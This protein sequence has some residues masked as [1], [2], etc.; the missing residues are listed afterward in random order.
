MGKVRLAK[1]DPSSVQPHRK[2]LFIGRSGGGKSV[3]MRH[4]LYHIRE[5]IDM[6][7]GFTPTEETRLALERFIPPSCVHDSLDLGVIERAFTTQKALLER[8]KERSLALIADDCAFDKQVWRS[9]TI[10]SAFMNG[11]HYRTCLVL[12]M[13]YMMDLSPDLRTNVDYVISTAEN[14]HANKR[15]L[16]Q[17]FF[18]VF[19]TYSEFDQVFSA[20][21]QDWSCIVLDQTQPSASVASSVFWWKADPVLPPFRLGR[22]VFFKLH[23]RPREEEQLSVMVR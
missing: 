3:A 22:P 17:S 18:G 9:P 19:R 23:E 12:S 14:I 13:Q 1:W 8:G 7:V 2:I 16:W 20:A 15:R 6:A 21:T 5:Q 11:R 4:V 10:R